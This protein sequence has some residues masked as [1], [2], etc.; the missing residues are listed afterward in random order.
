VK[1]TKIE[2]YVNDGCS[3]RDIAILENVGQTTIRYWL[4]KYKLKTNYTSKGHIC[5]CGETNPSNFYGHKKTICKKC[6]N[7]DRK[8]RSR[9]LKE[10]AVKYKGGKC[11]IC[12]YSKCIQALEFHHKDLSKKDLNFKS[13]KSWGWGRLKKEID[14]CILVCANCHR[15]IHHLD[16]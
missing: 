9:K 4:K 10:R 12:G 8:I 16:D 6:F 14:K 5:V 13:S 2:Q 7:E 1:K 15:E 3:T 11:S